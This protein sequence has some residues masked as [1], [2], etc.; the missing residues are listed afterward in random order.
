[1]V[2]DDRGLDRLH[3]AKPGRFHL[4]DLAGRYVGAA[5]GAGAAGGARK[6]LLGGAA[7]PV[8]VEEN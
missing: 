1:M 7:D 4:G 3:V 6:G 5:A 2:A 8:V